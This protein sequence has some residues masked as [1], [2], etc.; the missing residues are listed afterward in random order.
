[1]IDLDRFIRYGL[2]QLFGGSRRGQPLVAAFGAALVLLSWLRKR[3]GRDRLL[4]SE[5][6]EEGETMQLTF[7]RGPEV[8]DTAI[9]E[10]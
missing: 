9:I 10:G 4:F 7:R 6:L 5:T 3:S 8:I 1:V 2:R